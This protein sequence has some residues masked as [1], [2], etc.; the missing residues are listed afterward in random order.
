MKLTAR[1][2]YH[3]LLKEFGKTDPGKVSVVPRALTRVAM[4]DSEGDP[5]WRSGDKQRFGLFGMGWN[6]FLS[7]SQMA[8]IT[9]SDSNS[10]FVPSIHIPAGWK[11]FRNVELGLD[12]KLSEKD[13]VRQIFHYATGYDGDNLYSYYYAAID[14][15]SDNEFN[16]WSQEFKAG[17]IAILPSGSGSSGTTTPTLVPPEEDGPDWGTII[18]ITSSVIGIVIGVFALKDRADGKKKH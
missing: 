18:G 1:Q 11:Y 16:V 12:P 17:N 9:V 7:G 13:K 15:V 3:A 14:A 2:I 8:G 4:W 6:Q 5:T 10:V